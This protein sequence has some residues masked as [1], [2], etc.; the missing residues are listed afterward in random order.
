[1]YAFKRAFVV[2]ASVLSSAG[3]FNHALQ[4]RRRA[5]G[6]SRLR[7]NVEVDLLAGMK[8]PPAGADQTEV[9]NYVQCGKCKAVYP[10]D[11]D[12]IGN[13]K[14]VRPSLLRLRL[15]ARPHDC[16]ATS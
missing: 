9:V 15:G 16:W 8:S 3:A 14:K 4:V 11:I 12:V 2:L 13:G 5:L 1:M 10:I 6:F 7:S